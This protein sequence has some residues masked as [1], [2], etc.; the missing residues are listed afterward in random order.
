M[1]KKRDTQK[2]HTNCKYIL[3]ATTVTVKDCDGLISSV[4]KSKLSIGPCSSDCHRWE[5]VAVVAVAPE[6]DNLQTAAHIET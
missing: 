6:W 3:M 1:C 4:Y 2:R 5:V